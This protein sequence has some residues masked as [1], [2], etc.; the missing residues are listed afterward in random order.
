MSSAFRTSL[1]VCY[2]VVEFLL[3][4]ELIQFVDRRYSVLWGRVF[5]ISCCRP[6]V[7]SDIQTQRFNQSFCR[8][9]GS[10]VQCSGRNVGP[11]SRRQRHA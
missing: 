10:A 1:S 5:V 4:N 8:S 6:S 9:A 2:T 11:T 3:Q 7:E